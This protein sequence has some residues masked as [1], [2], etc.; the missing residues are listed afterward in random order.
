MPGPFGSPPARHLTWGEMLLS[1]LALAGGAVLLGGG[2]A[3]DQ[4]YAVGAGVVAI[5]LTP[6]QML[7]AQSPPDP[8]DAL[9]AQ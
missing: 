9:S 5:V 3:L 6:M 2:W 8:F 1:V 4:V 7:H